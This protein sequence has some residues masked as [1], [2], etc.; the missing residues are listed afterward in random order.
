[1]LSLHEI[2]K[3]ER[4]RQFVDWL[5]LLRLSE[6]RKAALT[7]WLELAWRWRL[8]IAAAFGVAGALWYFGL[9]AVL[10]PVI[11]VEAVVRVDFVQSVVASGHVEAE[12]RAN[13]GSQITGVVKDIPVAEGQTVKSGD[14]LIVL[15]D[16]EVRAAVSQ[17]EAVVAQAEARL[18]QLR[19][20]TMPSAEETLNTVLTIIGAKAPADGARAAAQKSSMIS[21]T[22]A[23]PCNR[24]E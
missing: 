21:R 14:V 10:G 12:Y 15:D 3:P 9:P 17:A 7:R 1:M 13:V 8:R 4:R 24:T 2:Q 22:E 11:L 6:V 20:L 5:R 19:E 18:R 16:R 23:K